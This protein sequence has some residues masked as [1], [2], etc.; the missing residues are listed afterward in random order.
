MTHTLS[1]LSFANKLKYINIRLFV[2]RLLAIFFTALIAAA[3]SCSGK[4]KSVSTVSITVPE[5]LV[6]SESEIRASLPEG[7]ISSESEYQL[8]I[9]V[10]SFSSGIETINYSGSDFNVGHREG[11]IKAVLKL[12]SGGKLIENRFIE[13]SG[14]GKDAVLNGLKDKIRAEFA[15]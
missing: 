5:S 13:A 3:T 12:N 11:N 4:V 2:M 14:N 1:A 6:V 15:E 7:L 9:A 8:E 10:Y